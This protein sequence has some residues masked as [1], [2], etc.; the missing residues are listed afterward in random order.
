MINPYRSYSKN[1]LDNDAPGDQV[2][3]L[4]DK[5]AEHISKAAKAIAENDIQA[6]FDYSQKTMAIMEG[7]LASLNRD[8]PERAEA[9]A[10]LEAYYR[11]MIMMIGR[12]NVYNDPQVCHSLEKGFRSMAEF[13][14]DAARILAAQ[15]IEIESHVTPTANVVA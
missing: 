15:Q 1:Q 12:V 11:S 10:S 14:R 6:R 5:A 3:A 9:A 13:W 8:T 4:F 2:A 7:L